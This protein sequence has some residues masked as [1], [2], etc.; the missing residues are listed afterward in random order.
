MG[1]D[2]RSRFGLVGTAGRVGPLELS[3]CRSGSFGRSPP[4]ATA[5]FHS[6]TVAAGM[7][8]QQRP[9]RRVLS[10]ATAKLLHDEAESTVP[11]IDPEQV[12][13]LASWGLAQNDIASFV[14]WSQS[15]LS[16]RFRSFYAFRRQAIQNGVEQGHGT[17]SNPLGMKDLWPSAS[18]FWKKQ[19]RV[20]N[21]Q[22]R[23]GS[24]GG[25]SSG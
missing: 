19:A 18:R 16:L 6:Q 13:K 5:A 3:T 23:H 21:G 17:Q 24:S 12:R 11:N 10:C 15:L 14:G 2:P 20:R 7:L 8:L 4:T 25:D 22:Q 9:T 1:K